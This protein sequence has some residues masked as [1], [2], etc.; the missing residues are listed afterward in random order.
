MIYEIKYILKTDIASENAELIKKFIE[1]A[2]RV[3]GF[4]A[5]EITVKPAE[6]NKD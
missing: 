6:E 5:L 3:S 4:E 2:A 1:N